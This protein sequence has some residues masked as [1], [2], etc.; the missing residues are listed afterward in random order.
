MDLTTLTIKKAHDHLIKGDFSVRELTQAYL[1]NIEKKNKNLNAYLEVF[2]DCLD[3]AD[4]ADKRLKNEKDNFML[5]VPMAF[6]DNM[7]IKGRNV[8]AGSKIL[9]GY[10][11][12]Y[13]AGVIKKL[14]EAGTIL[15]GRTNMDEFAMGTS[16]ENSAYGVTKNPHDLSRVPGG[17][18]GGSA[19][20]LAAN[21]TLGALGS[22]TGGSVRQPASFCGVVGFKPSYGRVSRS[23]LIAMASSLDQISPF[24]KTVED[25]EIIYNIIKGKDPQDSTSLDIKDE[26]YKSKSKMKIGVP[27]HFINE[28]T[29]QAVLDNFN[30][31]IKKMQDLGHEVIPI[32]IPNIKYS[33]AVYYIIVPAEVSSNL[34]RFDGVKYGLHKDGQDLLADYLLTRGEGFG[35]EVRRRIMLGT[36]VL[37][38][39]YYD[40]YYGKANQV[41]NL[42]KADFRKTFEEVNFVMTPTSPTVAFKI[43]EKASD[44]LALYL[45][46][47]FTVPANITGLPSISIPSGFALTDGKKLPLGLQFTAPFLA[48]SSLFEIAKQFEKLNG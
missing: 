45:A 38:S 3:Q 37:S 4:E 12:T 11:A 8:S 22:D 27:F 9:E 6:K 34:A 44:P 21:L 48:E 32:T 1:E 47:I 18:S 15:L 36:Y 23:G 26:I 17:S 33:L 13:D 19:A 10:K 31:S 25:A 29:E 5:G 24:A 20:A 28:G 30:Q 16:T 43:G 42:L 39:G 40:A 35:K 41:K 7:L 2:D 46:D 14:K